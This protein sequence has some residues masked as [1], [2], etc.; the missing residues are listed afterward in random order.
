MAKIQI[1]SIKLSELALKFIQYY[2][3]PPLNHERKKSAT[4]IG[5]EVKYRNLFKFLEESDN[6]EIKAVDFKIS[7]AKQFYHYIRTTTG[8]DYSVRAV[9]FVRA[10][11]N[12]GGMNEYININPLILFKIQKDR[13]KKVSSLSTKEVQQIESLTL[14]E[15][16]GKIRDVFIFQCYT[17][18]SYSDLKTVSKED[19][20][21]N[22]VDNRYYII[23]ERDKTGVEAI[24]PFTD[25]VKEIWKKYDYNLPVLSNCKY[26]LYLKTIGELAGIERELH[27]HM[28]R[29]TFTTMMLNAEG[30]SMEAVS[31]M[32]GHASVKTTETF[33]AKVNLGLISREMS[34]LNK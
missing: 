21:F 9:D 4:I 18:L 1:N 25:K 29:K 23:K 30:Y 13:I 14:P 2:R 17:G 12:W 20:F 22:E 19:L 32:S 33:Y 27:S 3:N 26:N 28:G 34:R 31:K 24:I 6:L 5:Y 7:I 10:V 16:I 15:G 8:N 11:L